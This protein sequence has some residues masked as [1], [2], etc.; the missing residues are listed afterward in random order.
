M[1]DGP[2]MNPG[3]IVGWPMLKI[4][5]PTNPANIKA[6]L[7]PGI[8]ASDE[9]N[10]H[11]TVYLV[12]VPDEPEFG[13]VTAVDA[14][15]KGTKGRYT[16]GLGIDQESAIFISRDMNGQPKYPATIEYHAP[17]L[18]VHGV[19]GADHRRDHA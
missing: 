1:T 17:G 16:L 10:V 18:H 5:Y 4:S 14:D 15:Y 19:R 6:L 11:L 2:K 7:P 12:P 13:I 8:D 3:D 9:S